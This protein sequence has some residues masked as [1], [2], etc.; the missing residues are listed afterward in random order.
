MTVVGTGLAVISGTADITFGAMT[1]SALIEVVSLGEAS[2]TFGALVV[3]GE[4][5]VEVTPSTG[6]GEISF[7]DLMVVAVGTIRGKSVDGWW[8]GRP[9]SFAPRR[10]RGC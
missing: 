7:G 6:V 1:I 8:P 5:T 10:R 9:F 2:I 3:E 4:G